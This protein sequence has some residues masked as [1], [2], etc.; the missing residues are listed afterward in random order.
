MKEKFLRIEIQQSDSC[1]ETDLH[2]CLELAP[3]L[4]DHWEIIGIVR[5]KAEKR[6][7]VYNVNLI[8]N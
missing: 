8:K 2:Q 4:K 3:L 7:L 6:K 5:D 1:G